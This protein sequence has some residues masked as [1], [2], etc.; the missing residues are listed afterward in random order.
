MKEAPREHFRW[1]PHTGGLATVKAKDYEAGEEVEAASP[2]ALWKQL[3]E[4]DGGRHALTPGDLLEVVAETGTGSLLIAKYIGFEPAQ[5]WI[6]EAKETK[7]DGTN[8]EMPAGDAAERIAA[9]TE[10]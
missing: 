6:P 10:S 3:A 8:L 2:Y 9:L 5:W 1:S 7:I 4:D